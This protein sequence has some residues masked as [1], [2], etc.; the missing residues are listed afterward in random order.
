M[1][2]F[3]WCVVLYFVGR[4]WLKKHPE[5]KAELRE[6]VMLFLGG[7]TSEK[8]AAITR[9]EFERR[10]QEAKAPH[11]R[12]VADAPQ[13]GHG[14]PTPRWHA[15]KKNPAIAMTTTQANHGTLP[16]AT[17]PHS[18]ARPRKKAEKQFQEL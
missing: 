1:E 5:K 18:S 10:Q 8:A 13:V 11:P 3:F 15:A 12:D 7:T 2:F 4:R 16:A 14:L 17:K 9:R 6:Y